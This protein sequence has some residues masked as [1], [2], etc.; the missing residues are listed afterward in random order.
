MEN[1]RTEPI[2]TPLD[3]AMVM[4]NIQLV[5]SNSS[6]PVLKLEANLVN[7]DNE[8]FMAQYG[9]PVY[10][11]EDDIPVHYWEKYY[12]LRDFEVEVLNTANDSGAFNSLD[13]I[14]GDEEDPVGFGYILKRPQHYEITLNPHGFKKYM[15][16][17]TSIADGLVE[18]TAG[19]SFENISSPSVEI[20]T[21][22]YKFS[23]LRNG[24]VMDIILYCFENYPNQ[25]IDLATLK[26]VLHINGVTN[27]T[28]TLRRSLFDSNKGRLRFFVDSSSQSITVKD[29]ATIS[30]ATAKS[31][32]SSDKLA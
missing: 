10:L 6:S 11:N 9:E 14:L 17:V 18:V 30:M 3:T 22:S 26:D 19:L 12:D 5:D 28:E 31:F 25:Q 7:K 16:E 13:I 21:K 2:A 1:S 8:Y 23:P 27:L 24:N 32:A 29:S 15:A 4:R 20:G